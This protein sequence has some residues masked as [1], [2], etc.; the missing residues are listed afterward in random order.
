[1]AAVAGPSHRCSSRCETDRESASGAVSGYLH[2]AEWGL[3]GLW[4]E[5][6][7][8]LALMVVSV[9]I[10][11]LIGIP[12]GI[13][14]GRND[15]AERLLRPLLDAMQTTP[16]FVYL[17]PVILFFGVARVPSMICHCDIRPAAGD[18]LYQPGDSH[19]G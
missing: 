13:L 1:M 16:A 17:I 4:D 19:C 18:P 12:L 14:T 7:A 8:T 3:L 9:V 11:L 6:M 5:S 15:R 10:A 2:P